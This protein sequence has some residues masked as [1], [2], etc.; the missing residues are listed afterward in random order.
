[1]I[2]RK[3]QSSPA[4]EGMVLAIDLGGGDPKHA[5]MRARLQAAGLIAL[6]AAAASIPVS[7]GYTAWATHRAL[8]LEWLVNG[9]NCPVVTA[10]SPAARGAK[11]PAP[12]VYKDVGFVYQIGDVT[13]AAVPERSLFSHATF[14]VCQFDA[15]AGVAVTV[16]GRTT[17]F[18]PGVGHGATV[19]VDHGRIAC[20]TSRGMRD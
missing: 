18:E 12:F 1:M 14:P 15:P 13:C 6:V 3:Q 19:S 17:V 7:E 20:V 2:F 9:P 16:A 11:P 8:R 10:L 5:R 4:R